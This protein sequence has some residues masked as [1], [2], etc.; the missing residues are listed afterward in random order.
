MW[1]A[2][3]CVYFYS[4]LFLREFFRNRLFTYKSEFCFRKA[5]N[6]FRRSPWTNSRSSL[7]ITFCIHCAPQP[8]PARQPAALLICSLLL[9]C[10]IVSPNHRLC[11]FSVSRSDYILQQLQSIDTCI[12]NRHRV[13]ARISSPSI[14][15]PLCSANYHFLPARGSV[16]LTG[17]QH[18]ERTISYSFLID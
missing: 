3:P 17:A 6:I 11:V 4:K 5:Q 13:E 9:F 2:V 10:S 16:E 14:N 7:I 1:F 8:H 12:S 18:T 15:S